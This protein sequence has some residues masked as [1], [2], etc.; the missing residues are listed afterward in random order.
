[1]IFFYIGL[2]NG[3]K[4]VFLPKR[5]DQWQSTV[6]SR[7][8]VVKDNRLEVCWNNPAQVQILPTTQSP[9]IQGLVKIL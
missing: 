7:G 8:R 3:I 4:I 6:C 1:M 5:P 9:N 2:N